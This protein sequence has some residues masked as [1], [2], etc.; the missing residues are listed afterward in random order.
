MSTYHIAVVC[1]EVAGD[2][3]IVCCDVAT[4]LN[5]R[6]QS[7]GV[8]EIV[9][10]FRK[11]IIYFVVLSQSSLSQEREQTPYASRYVIGL[12]LLWIL[13]TTPNALSRCPLYILFTASPLCR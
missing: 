11:Q 10:A 3:V 13:S 9:G 1:R 7:K 5:P 4:R 12:A 8:I 2:T 6:G